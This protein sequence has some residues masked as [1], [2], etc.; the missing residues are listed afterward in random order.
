MGPT[1]SVVT[2]ARPVT[3]SRVDSVFEYLIEVDMPSLKNRE[4]RKEAF[5]FYVRVVAS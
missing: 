3:V 2:R 5:S 1:R 4:E